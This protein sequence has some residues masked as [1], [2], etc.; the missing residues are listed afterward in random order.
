[1]PASG[2]APWFKVDFDPTQEL[3][4]PYIILAEPG[5]VLTEP[6]YLIVEGEHLLW[7]EAVAYDP[8][9]DEVR[10]SAIF[11][12]VSDTGAEWE[13]VGEAPVLSAESVGRA[14]VVALP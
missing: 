11:F 5:E 12:A 9:T 4:Q 13:I 7:Y 8:D 1:M 10:E 3:I 6:Y 14:R 2:V